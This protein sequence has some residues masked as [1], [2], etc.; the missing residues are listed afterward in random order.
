VSEAF[1][2]KHQDVEVLKKNGK[3]EDPIKSFLEL[4]DFYLDNVCKKPRR[5]KIL[6]IVLDNPDI[7]FEGIKKTFNYPS[8][9]PDQDIISN[10]SLFEHLNALVY[11][12]YV[13]KEKSRPTK[14]RVTMQTEVIR[15]VAAYAKEFLIRH[16]MKKIGISEAYV[17]ELSHRT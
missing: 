10:G 2:K 11:L 17:K 8:G 7:N 16:Q 12:G 14:Y 13:Q 1:D 3:D 15:K 9:E 5:V 6:Q 4:V